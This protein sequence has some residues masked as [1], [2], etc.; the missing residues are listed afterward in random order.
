MRGRSHAS[1]AERYAGRTV[2]EPHAATRTEAPFLSGSTQAGSG[3]HCMVCLSVLL[4][5]NG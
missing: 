5:N 3:V 2:G 4:A 1:R